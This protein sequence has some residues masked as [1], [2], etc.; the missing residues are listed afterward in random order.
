MSK[1]FKASVEATS[2]HIVKNSIKPVLLVVYSKK[3]VTSYTGLVQSQIPAWDVKYC[4]P[5]PLFQQEYKVDVSSDADNPI[6]CD[7]GE[8][9]RDLEDI[10]TDQVYA[11]CNGN[12]L[13]FESEYYTNYY[14]V[15]RI[16][17]P[18]T[19]FKINR[20]NE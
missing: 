15:F 14:N 16:M 1:Q 7:M 2:I 13:F 17:R 3:P 4:V 11:S 18:K 9:Y 12:D 8:T 5:S 6:V 19:N 10:V 20:P